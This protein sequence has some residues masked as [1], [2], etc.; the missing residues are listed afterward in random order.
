MMNSDDLWKELA[1][2]SGEPKV[3]QYMDTW[4]SER[5]YPVIDLGTPLSFRY[6][7]FIELTWFDVIYKC[8][9]V[10]THTPLFNLA[11]MLC[12][13][14]LLFTGFVVVY[15]SK[16][17]ISQSINASSNSTATTWWIPLQIQK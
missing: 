10:L 17:R 16:Y 15:E 7:L 9:L 1:T 4:I 8:N 3:K 12:I 14:Y 2:Q 11:T 6:L 5:G 13:F